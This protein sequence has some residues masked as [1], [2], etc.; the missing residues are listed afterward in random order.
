MVREPSGMVRGPSGM[1]R[2]PGRVTGGAVVVVLGVSSAT[3][4][5]FTATAAPARLQAPYK[6]D[7][8]L[9]PTAPCSGDTHVTSRIRRQ[10]PRMI[11]LCPDL[12]ESVVDVTLSQEDAHD[13][14]R[15]DD[16]DDDDGDEE[17]SWGTGVWPVAP[18]RSG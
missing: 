10:I 9:T 6:E 1:V 4:P 15:K 2:G 3:P 8:K 7:S 13:N 16:G 11:R 14:D 17:A 12:A 18:G 5:H